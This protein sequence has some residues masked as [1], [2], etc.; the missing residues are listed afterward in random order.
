MIQNVNLYQPLLRTASIPLGPRTIVRL[1]LLFVLA[2]AAVY[3]AGWWTKAQ[4]SAELHRL[5]IDTR[6]V[7]GHLR[8][9]EARAR[10]HRPSPLLLSEIARARARLTARRAALAV[11][12]NHRY[13]NRHG[14]SPVLVALGRAV[15]PG[16]WLTRIAIRRGGERVLLAG[17]AVRAEAVPAYVAR[18]LLLL[19]RA[20]DPVP[21]FHVLFLRRMKK[22]PGLFRFLV[23]SVA[24]PKAHTR[25]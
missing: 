25:P 17:R 13:G 19:H 21:R 8:S 12:A 22:T 24:P 11:L 3:G 14:F 10:A 15:V 16:L 5:E 6:I 23:S 9:L 1:W 20:D 7:G 2:L 18:L 4:T